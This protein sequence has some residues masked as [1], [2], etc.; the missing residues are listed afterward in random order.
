MDSSARREL[1]ILNSISDGTPVSQRALARRLGIALGL[2]NLY[3]KRLARK[4][5]I[6][7]TRIP[8]NRIKYL[9]TPRGVAQKSRLTYE[10]M[11]YSLRLYRDAR[12]TLSE[13]LAPLAGNGA[14]RIAIHGTGEA[15]ELTYLT[16][17][18][19]GIEPAA[20]L[21]GTGSGLFLGQRVQDVRTATPTDYDLIVVATLD[22]PDRQ[23]A[24]LIELGAPESSLI[25][26]RAPR[27]TSRNGGRVTPGSA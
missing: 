17:R 6:K 15:A 16:L 20:I 4:G 8:P 24:E 12:Q 2:I 27:R 5:Y 7:A 22:V 21:D 25:C 14:K 10:Y 26:L 11:R 3:L 19:F 18:E 1:E 23:I 9:M 13:T